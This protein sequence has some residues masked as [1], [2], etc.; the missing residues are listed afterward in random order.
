MKIYRKKLIANFDFYV[1]I[2][3][4]LLLSSFL[5]FT[6]N[7]NTPLGIDLFLICIGLGIPIFCASLF[8]YII[9]EDYQL[10]IGNPIYMFRIRKY[11]FK[12]IE[13][14]IIG[15]GRGYN[16]Y[17]KIYIGGR[18]F[19]Y[20]MTLVEERDFMNIVEELK[21]K[22]I[23]LELDHLEEHIDKLGF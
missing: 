10:A 14:V 7:I 3:F 23:P 2:I 1:T 12:E 5:F 8:N 20:R 17:I 19:W 4:P 16:P 9:I 18:S 15:I 22:R 21:R 6:K 13:K 11:G